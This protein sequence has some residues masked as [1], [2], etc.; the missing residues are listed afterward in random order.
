MEKKEKKYCSLGAHISFPV[1][2][3]KRIEANSLDCIR[4]E[5]P[6]YGKCEDTN[7]LSQGLEVMEFYKH[8]NKDIIISKN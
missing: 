7:I 1:G 5:C 2:T 6:L 4:N 3:I 8:V